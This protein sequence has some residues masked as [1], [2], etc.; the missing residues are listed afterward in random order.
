MLGVWP[1]ATA[2]S[3]CQCRARIGWKAVCNWNTME[4]AAWAVE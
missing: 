4:D 1:A 3:R 2:R